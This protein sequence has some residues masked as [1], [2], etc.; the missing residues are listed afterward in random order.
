MTAMFAR[1]EQKAQEAVD[2]TQTA[3]CDFW[4]MI[5]DIFDFFVLT[6][7]RLI[8]VVVSSGDESCF[9]ARYL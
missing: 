2:L 4:S 1:L 3:R 9:F 7:V 5:Q 6:G 8:F